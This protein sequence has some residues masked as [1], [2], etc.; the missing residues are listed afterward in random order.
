MA[1]PEV[2]KDIDMF[3]PIQGY[4]GKGTHLRRNY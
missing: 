1:L 3:L 4:G 2:T